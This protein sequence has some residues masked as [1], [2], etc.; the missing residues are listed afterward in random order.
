M[1]RSILTPWLAALACLL[2]AP[3]EAQDAGPGG[4]EAVVLDYARAFAAHDYVAAARLI[5]PD[6]LAAFM[7]LLADLAA[8]D[9]TGAFDVD[10]DAAP[11]EA[12]AEFLAAIAGAE[13]L[14]DE[15]LESARAT[16]VGSVPEGDSLRH[17]VVRSRFEMMGTETSGVEVTT[18]RRT[19]DGW[20]VTFD[21]RLRQFQAGLEAALA[22]QG[23]AESDDE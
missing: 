5:D 23:G 7:G 1:P 18:V 22:A 16:V 15:A 4:A 20:A 12:F 10:P 11:P 14:V 6:E 3:A 21:A 9:E 13:P 8:L 17:V 2:A 19:D